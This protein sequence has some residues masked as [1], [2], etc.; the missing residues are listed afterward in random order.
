MFTADDLG[1]RRRP[2][3][4]ATAQD[5]F[6]CPR[7]GSSLILRAGL[8]LSPHFAHRA[9]ASCSW[10]SPAIPATGLRS[11]DTDP[12]QGRLFDPDAFVGLPSSLP[13]NQPTLLIRPTLRTRAYSFVQRLFRRS[14]RPSFPKTVIPQDRRSV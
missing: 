8:I 4:Q 3:G 5:A 10:S 9:G 2:A 12:A 6:S 7:C 13:L 1:G 14:P 11:G